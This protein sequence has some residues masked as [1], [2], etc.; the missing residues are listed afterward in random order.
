[1]SSEQVG[2]MQCWSC[3]H[4][5]SGRLRVCKKCWSGVEVLY[6]EFEGKLSYYPLDLGEYRRRG[7]VVKGYVNDLGG[8]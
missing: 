1:M 5:Q 2:L 4:V 6:S 3:G 7:I 8:R